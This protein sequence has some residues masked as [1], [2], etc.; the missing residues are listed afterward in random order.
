MRI[1]VIEDDREA[2]AYLVKAFREAGHAADQAQDGL[3]GYAMAEAGH[4]DVLVV[5]RMLPKLDGLSVI[6]SLREQKVETPA[7]ILSALS[8]VDDR[9]K[10]LRAGGDD[11]L[12]K[13]YSFSELLARVEVLARRG[14]RSG[15]GEP[16][17]YRVADLELDRLSHRVTRGGQDVLLQPREFRLLEYLVRH[18]GQVVTRT[19]LL[20]HV[21]DYHFDPQTNVIDVHVS[22]L[23]A[24]IDRG[25]DK[26]LI[27]TV[28]GAGY[29]VRDGAR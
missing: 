26:P 7:L 16:T 8:Q 27:H 29:M 9:V 20:E 13:P 4:Y 14:G 19:M 2:L 11:Y 17:S 23:R 25:F 3:D 18:A 15:G 22:R 12:S 6:R 1:L 28:R 5:D 24:K 21:W 10:G